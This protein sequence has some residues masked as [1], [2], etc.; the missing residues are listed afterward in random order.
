M[1]NI[2]KNICLFIFMWICSQPVFSA[3]ALS[4]G[5]QTESNGDWA[6]TATVF[7]LA[8]EKEVRNVKLNWMQ[9]ED[10]ELYKIYRNGDL[11]GEAKGDT[12]DDYGLAVGKTFT[13]HVEAFKDG[14][15]VATAISQQATTFTP[16]GEGRIYDNLN[17]KYITEERSG[18]PQGMKIGDLYFSYKIENR[19]AGYRE[20]F[21]NRA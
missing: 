16:I 12:Y 4:S 8:G 3:G 15:K 14:R 20:L 1:M 5:I 10:A 6:V 11:I 13:Y 19:L 7:R 9:R 2:I 21:Q 17:G 18:K